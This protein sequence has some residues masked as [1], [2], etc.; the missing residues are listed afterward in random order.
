MPV[1]KSTVER[2]AK[3]WFAESKR[4]QTVDVPC[5]C[6]CGKAIRRARRFRSGHDAKLLAR[7]S[8]DIATILEAG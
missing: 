7:Y 6:G 8:K 1:D 3:A 5:S 4:I 2:L